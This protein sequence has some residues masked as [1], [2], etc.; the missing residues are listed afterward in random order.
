M[1]LNV[2]NDHNKYV[3]VPQSGSNPKITPNE[4]IVSNVSLT[5]LNTL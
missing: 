3:G 5:I 2:T 1:V 4:Y